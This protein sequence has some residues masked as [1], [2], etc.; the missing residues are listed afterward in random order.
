MSSPPPSSKKIQIQLF[1]MYFYFLFVCFV[2]E[3][4][5][6]ACIPCME[7]EKEKDGFGIVHYLHT[8]APSF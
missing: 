2:F 1:L 7:I 5:Y 3:C 6:Q 8:R 4:K